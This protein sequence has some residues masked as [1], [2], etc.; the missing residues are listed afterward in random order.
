MLQLCGSHCLSGVLFLAGNEVKSEKMDPGNSLKKYG[1]RGTIL[2]WYEIQSAFYRAL[3]PDNV[4]F[5]SRSELS[6][7]HT[8]LFMHSICGWM[9]HALKSVFM[10][11]GTSSM[12]R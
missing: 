5:N 2:G 1:K 3:P 10:K 6:C 12:P 8:L 11:A 9:K 4:V 7:P